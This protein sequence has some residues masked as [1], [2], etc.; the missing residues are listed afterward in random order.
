MI[1]KAMLHNTT[2]S[3]PWDPQWANCKVYCN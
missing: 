2:D 3:L 1:H